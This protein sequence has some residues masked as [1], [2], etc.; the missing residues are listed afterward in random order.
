[1]ADI[2]ALRRQ[3][4]D[5]LNDHTS[6][7]SAER[8]QERMKLVFGIFYDDEPDEPAQAIGDALTDLIHVAADRGVDFEQTLSQALRRWTDERED[9]GLE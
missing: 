8:M 7:D 6:D 1:M 9:W 3:L 4:N 2:D 5:N